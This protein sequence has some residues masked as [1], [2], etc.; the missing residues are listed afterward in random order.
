VAA[1]VGGDGGHIAAR[2]QG[3]HFAIGQHGGEAVQCQLVLVLHGCARHHGHHGR[4]A[5]R[6]V[7][8]IQLDIRRTEVEALAGGRPGGWVAGNAAVI[9]GHGLV[10]Q[11]HDVGPARFVRV[12]GRAKA[13]QSHRD[14]YRVQFHDL[15]FLKVF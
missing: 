5:L 14:N 15:V 6:Q 10:A 8:R 2:F 7:L 3:A 11:L 1:A 12:D 4:L 13:A 9:G